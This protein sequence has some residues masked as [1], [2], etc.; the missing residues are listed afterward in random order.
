MDL[1]KLL[2]NGWMKSVAYLA[3]MSHVLAGY[4]ILITANLLWGKLGMFLTLIPLII[5]VGLK[6]FWYDLRYEE[7]KETMMDSIFD[8]SMYGLGATLAILAVCLI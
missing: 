4:S 6:E 1:K 5:L 7:P 2:T 3:Q 8:A